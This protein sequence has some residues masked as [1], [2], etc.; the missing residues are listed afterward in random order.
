M[1]YSFVEDSTSNNLSYYTYH[2]DDETAFYF[3]AGVPNIDWF[4]NLHCLWGKCTKGLKHRCCGSRLAKTRCK[5]KH[6]KELETLR[7]LSEL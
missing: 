1:N 2:L 6:R 5:N 7:S 4:L 3:C